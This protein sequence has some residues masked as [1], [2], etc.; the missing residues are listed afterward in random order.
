MLKGPNHWILTTL[1]LLTSVTQLFGKGLQG[2]PSYPVGPQPTQFAIADFN[3]DGRPDLVVVQSP[4]GTATGTVQVLLRNSDGSYAAPLTSV[5]T[6]NLSGIAA[7]DFNGD[8][9]QDAALI[10]SIQK[11]LTI[12]IGNGDGTLTLAASYA[13]GDN[14]VFV[15]AKDINQDSL[16]DLVVANY[17][18]GTYSVYLSNG[19][20]SFAAKGAVAAGV[21]HPNGIAIGDLDHDGKVD[22]AISGNDNHYSI[23]RGLG[24][25]SFGVPIAQLVLGTNPLA[26]AMGDLNGDGQEDLVITTNTVVVLSG[27]GDLSFKPAQTYPVQLRPN[28]VVLADIDGDNTRDIVVSNSFSNSVSVL[29]NRGDGTFNAAVNYAAGVFPVGVG[30]QDLDGDGLTDVAVLN[31]GLPQEGSVEILRNIGH[32]VLAGG[33]SSNFASGGTLASTIA[34]TI[35]DYDGDGRPDVAQLDSAPRVNVLLNSGGYTFS[36]KSVLPVSEVQ[37]T[38]IVT[39]DIDGDGKLDI[40]VVGQSSYVFFGNGDG[41]FKTPVQGAI[42]QDTLNNSHWAALADFNHDHKLDLVVSNVDDHQTSIAVLLGNRD[43]TF[44]SPSFPLVSAFS[45]DV[46]AFDFNKDG[47]QDIAVATSLGL[48]VLLGKG[49]GTFNPAQH[50]PYTGAVASVVQLALG[51]LNGDGEEDIIVAGPKTGLPKSPDSINV[52]LG[53]S[54][55]TFQAT[56]AYA[57]G[58]GHGSVVAA[59]FNGDGRSDVAVGD[60]SSFDVFP[61]DAGGHLGTPVRSQAGTGGPLLAVA[62]ITGSAVPDLILPSANDTLA[63]FPNTGGTHVGDSANPSPS[64]YQQQLHINV[65]VTQAIS[66]YPAP[67]GTIHISEGATSIGD[68]QLSAPEFVVSS[69]SVGTHGLQLSYSGDANYNPRALPAITQ[70]VNKAPTSTAL[71]AVATALVGEPV[72]LAASVS[73]QFGGVPTGSVEF[74]DGS[75]SLGTQSLDASSKAAFSLSTLPAGL[76]T[77]TASYA[78]D[79]NFVAS[80]SAGVSVDIQNPTTTTVSAA[81]TTATVGNS[82][83]LTATI[84]SSGVLPTGTVDF[85]AN[86]TMALGSATLDGS[87]NA[88]LNTTSVPG[89]VNAVTASYRGDIFS[90]KSVS[91]PV[92]VSV[93]DF[94]IT[95]QPTSATLRAG[96]SATITL[97]IA[98]MAGF[99]SSVS[100]VCNNLP[101]LATCTFSPATVTAGNSPVTATLAI[102]TAGSA[103]ALMPPAFPDSQNGLF[104]VALATIGVLGIAIV[105]AGTGKPRLMLGI[106]TVVCFAAFVSCGGGGGGSTQPPSVPTTPQGTSSVTVV[107]S[108]SMNGSTVS[109]QVPISITVTP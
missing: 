34:L 26:I 95:A 28:A 94:A 86:G 100:F 21:A 97:S 65:A 19:N 15:V 44:Q 92:S 64:A 53:N 72:S 61:S 69:L 104:A 13:T 31:Q 14:P 63:V 80:S 60:G 82:I 37:P 78:G 70:V 101:S 42:P 57:L 20:G 77:L 1:L 96:Q 79:H 108:S 55:G 8:G 109:H 52:F 50:F 6:A 48:A 54:D 49:D 10:D 2:A 81:P 91:Q 45:N 3:G 16:A 106:L 74:L 22:L 84:R 5:A 36:L 102:K 56:T 62:D 47:N 41:T 27:N 17:D 58:A 51:D 43:G 18:D 7:G 87:G 103:A 71:A 59:D 12:L 23:A 105:S 83:A 25:G 38:A 30:A 98:G 46:A 9:K 89:G 4:G 39:G 32:G 29:L 40:V 11:T 73:G 67:T 90:A 85:I 24:D 93:A 107:A 68:I 99:N 75:A 76:H 66:A 33:Y 88:L 35:G